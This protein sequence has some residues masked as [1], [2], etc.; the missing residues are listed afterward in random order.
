[1]SCAKTAESIDLPFGLWMLVGRR[2]QEFNHIRQVTPVYP[3]GREHWCHLANTIEPC[4]CDADAVLMSNYFNH[5]FHNW[6]C[7]L[8]EVDL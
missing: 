7:Q 1:V 2:K 8:T 3:H 5:L 6:L 4:V